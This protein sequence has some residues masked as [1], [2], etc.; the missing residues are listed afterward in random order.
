MRGAAHKS[1]WNDARILHRDI[2]VGSILIVDAD[3]YQSDFVGLLH[4]FDHSSMVHGGVGRG[5]S[6]ESDRSVE[7]VTAS[8]LGA[9]ARLHLLTGLF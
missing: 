2:S 5:A 9:A 4:N 3:L 8:S 6:F 7:Y 1:L